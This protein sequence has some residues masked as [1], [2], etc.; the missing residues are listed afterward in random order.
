[1]GISHQT[2]RN[3]LRHYM[4]ELDQENIEAAAALRS[5]EFA[6]LQ[7]AGEKIEAAVFDDDELGR[8]P[9][10]VKLS[11]SR[12]KPYALDV[13]PIRKA[14]ITQRKEIINEVFMSLRTSISASAFVEV[15]TSLSTDDS[16]NYVEEAFTAASSEGIEPPADLIPGFGNTQS[17]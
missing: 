16:V 17:S 15:L 12:R 13:Q 7:R 4:S 11:E 5:E 14:D 3:D 9:D 10:L 2:V 8:I 1:M 6:K